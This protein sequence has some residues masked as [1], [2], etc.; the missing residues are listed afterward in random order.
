MAPRPP[1]PGERVAREQHLVA[2]RARPVDEQRPRHLPRLLRPRLEERRARREVGPNPWVLDVL[3]AP[4]VAGLA[5]DPDF[6]EVA[7]REVPAHLADA[8]RQRPA[9]IAGPPLWAP[10]DSR[11]LRVD[12]RAQGRLAPR[13][14]LDVPPAPAREQPVDDLSLVRGRAGPVER[15]PQAVEVGGGVVAED[16]G[17]V[18]DPARAQAGPLADEHRVPF[19]AKARSLEHVGDRQQELGVRVVS[20]RGQRRRVGL[21]GR[22]LHAREVLAHAPADDARDPKQPVGGARR[23]QA[24]EPR[25]AALREDGCVFLEVERP[26]VERRPHARAVGQ[27]GHEPHRRSLPCCV[28]LGVA[29]GTARRAGVIG[30]QHIAADAHR[31]VVPRGARVPA[32]RTRRPTAERRDG[33]GA[34]RNARRCPRSADREASGVDAA[35]H[36]RRLSDRR[37]RRADRA[38]GLSHGC[39]RWFGADRQGRG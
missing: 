18:P 23:R 3:P 33:R 24:H 36:D 2:A 31:R 39:A 32:R 17:L 8:V 11:D 22:H 35:G 37:C 21:R 9:Q 38:V 26:A 20:R 25:A 19:E 34:D 6:D 27:P 1:L 14:G 13:R 10:P 5:A 7:G 4:A 30:S 16:A 28:D 15:P 12:G 29:R